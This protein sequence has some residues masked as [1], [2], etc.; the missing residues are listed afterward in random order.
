MNGLFLW[1]FNGNFNILN[2]GFA[3][4]NSFF[5]LAPWLLLFLIPAITMK[6]FADEFNNG[7]I[8][9]LQTKPIG[10]WQVVLGKFWASFLLI[11]I[12]IIPT[13]VYVYSVDSLANPKENID[14]GSIIGSYFGL[15]FLA[16]TYSAIGLFSS[17]L[18]KN[19]IVAFITSICITFFLFYGLDEIADL[20]QSISISKL[21]ISEHFKSISRGVLDTRDI[22]YF[23]SVT[24]FFL[25]VTKTRLENE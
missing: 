17:S 9:I 13:F 24:L 25:F 8:E 7:T 16:A 18:T 3:D 14:F 15:L 21:G 6:S 22:I 12:A 19:Q 2:A 5:F 11:I 4:V 20:F 1:V 23:V 10:N